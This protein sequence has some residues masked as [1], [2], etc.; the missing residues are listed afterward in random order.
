M[1]LPL[2]SLFTRSDAEEKPIRIP[3]PSQ[4]GIPLDIFLTCATGPLLFGLL[5]A[6]A[7]A[8]VIQDLGLASEEVFRGDRLPVL[9]FP[10]HGATNADTMSDDD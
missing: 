8:G 10:V 3:Q 9:N 7:I 6:K 4:S 2:N 5:A 1:P